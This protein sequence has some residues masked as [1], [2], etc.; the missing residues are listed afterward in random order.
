MQNLHW[1][2]LVVI[3][4]FFVVVFAIAAYYSKKAGKDTDQF[5]LS[6]RDMPWYI[7]GTAMVATT[8][9]ADTPLAVTELV[10]RNG[11]AGNWL[12]WNLAIGGMLTVFFFA[13]LWRRAGIMTDVEYVELRYSGRAA[14]LL[15]GF[16]SI[17]LG[18]FM[19]AIV[20]GW[21]NK[22]MEKIFRVTVPEIDP[23]LLVVISASLLAVY[24]SAS[25]L[26]GTARTDS[27]QFV[28]AMIGCIILAAIVVA[29]PQIGGLVALKQKLAPQVL[30]FL[31]RIGETTAGG[32]TGGVLAIPAGAFMAYIGLQWWSAWYPGADPGGGGYVAQRMMSAKDE[33]HSLFATLWFT[34]AHYTIR[35]WPWILVALAALVLLPRVESPE[36]IQAE[37]PAL[38]ATVVEAY[39]NPALQRSADPSYQSPEFQAMYEKYENT[40][41]PGVMFPK[42]M[43][44]YMPVGMIGLLIAVFLAAYMSTLASQLNWGTS[45]I[46]ND[47]YR[48]FIKPDADE[49]HYVRVSRLGIVLMT[50]FSL[51]VTR[52]FLT[53][54]SGAWEFVINASAGMGAVLILR[55]FWWRIN[56]WSEIS[57]MIAPLIIYPVARYGFE[58]QPPM[59]LYPTVLG[60]TIVWLLVT[61]LTRPVPDNTLIEFYRRTHPGGIGWRR[62]AGKVPDVQ[63]DTGFGRLFL[64]WGLGVVMVYSFLFGLGDLLFGSY[65]SGAGILALGLIS[66]AIIWRDLSRRGL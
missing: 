8:F 40:V 5:F 15:R 49:R 28:F 64:D 4:V 25:G 36:M 41:D 34:I 26:L 56:A 32:V 66:G 16:R 14:A 57:A 11:I 51:I 37:N 31:P 35:P 27:F 54:I 29:L 52:Y 63:G 1:L 3:V 47:F 19:N 59:T 12:W 55:W 43:L 10:A 65:L 7:A 9:A 21:V 42:L 30:D 60:T 33:K 46:I 45:Y 22:A 44:R 17:Y 62:I 23:F 13:R 58:I 38:Y 24:A 6:G 20:L 53:R 2:D 61:F 18:L 48:R 39:N 50:I